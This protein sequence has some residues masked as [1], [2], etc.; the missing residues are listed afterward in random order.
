MRMLHEAPRGLIKPLCRRVLE[1][2]LGLH[3]AC[4]EKEL[5]THMHTHIS[6]FFPTDTGVFHKALMEMVLCKAPRGLQSS[7]RD[8]DLQSL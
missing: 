7:Y 5:C 1:S 2:P 4:I 8:W 6:V 3:K